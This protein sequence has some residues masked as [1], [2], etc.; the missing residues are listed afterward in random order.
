ML[1]MRAVLKGG[2]YEQCRSRSSCRST[3]LGTTM[4]EVAMG[5]AKRCVLDGPLRPHH[6]VGKSMRVERRR[7]SVTGKQ[8][9]T[10]IYGQP[11]GRQYL[12]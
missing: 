2:W 7:A 12:S 3:E 6:H 9:L 4:S 1:G 10:G 11:A 5:K 8:E